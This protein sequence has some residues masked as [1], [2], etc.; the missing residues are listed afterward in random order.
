M[1]KDLAR[2]FKNHQPAPSARCNKKV[3]TQQQTLHI[4]R[5]S[6]TN[7]LVYPPQNFLRNKQHH[8][9]IYQKN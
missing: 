5:T 6:I 2:T 7:S 3:R 1:A 8:L 4:T 9:P